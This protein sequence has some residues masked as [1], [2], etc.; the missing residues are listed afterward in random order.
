MPNS[1]QVGVRDSGVGSD[2]HQGFAEMKGSISQR[3][4]DPKDSCSLR[5][6]AR[7]HAMAP[8]CVRQ[9]SEGES[10]SF[11]SVLVH[12]MAPICVRRFSE[13]ES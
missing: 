13:G 7:M 9:F 5:E 4:I 1:Q 10:R 12:A 3:G 6:A 8:F 11:Y 2:T